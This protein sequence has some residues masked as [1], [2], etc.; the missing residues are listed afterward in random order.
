[1]S[2]ATLTFSVKYC[3][4]RV[5][6]FGASVLHLGRLSGLSPPCHALFRNS[7]NWCDECLRGVPR[8]E[9]RNYFAVART[10]A[11]SLLGRRTAGVLRPSTANE[12]APL[13]SEGREKKA[14]MRVHTSFSYKYSKKDERFCTNNHVQCR[15]RQDRIGDFGDRRRSA[16]DGVRTDSVVVQISDLCC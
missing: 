14:R 2:A 15:A 12:C 4:A 16:H 1:M 9:N 11:R 6:V 10:D 7:S 3:F 13:L 5:V 8:V